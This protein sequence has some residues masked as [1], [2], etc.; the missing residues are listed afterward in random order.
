MS[1][2]LGFQM[3][4]EIVDVTM[5][6]IWKRDDEVEQWRTHSVHGVCLGFPAEGEEG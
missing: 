2:T 4:N 5:R 3:T 1:L 6:Q